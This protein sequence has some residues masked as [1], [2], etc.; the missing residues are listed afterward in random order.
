MKPPNLD[1]TS[2]ANGDLRQPNLFE[3]PHKQTVNELVQ[4]C[5][6]SCGKERGQH[7]PLSWKH[8][9]STLIH[10]KK[11]SS[12]TPKATFWLISL[13]LSVVLLGGGGGGEER[14]L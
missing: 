5:W 9:C 10:G 12:K 7:L 13:R 1:Q 14:G 11:K 2:H 6:T 4:V 3:L 8:L